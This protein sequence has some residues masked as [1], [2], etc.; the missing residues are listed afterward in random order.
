FA[1]Q[2]FDGAPTL[3][4]ILDVAGNTL[5]ELGLV[6]QP[7]SQQIPQQIG[8]GVPE[9]LY[10]IFAGNSYGVPEQLKKLGVEFTE[11]KKTPILMSL[12]EEVKLAAKDWA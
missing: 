7:G 12:P 2:E 10:S 1:G 4:D 3:K 5:H 6:P 11:T 9:I 8:Q